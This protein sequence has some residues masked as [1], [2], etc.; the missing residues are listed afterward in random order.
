M[1]PA[2]RDPS[3]ADRMGRT[4][5]IDKLPAELRDALHGWLRDPGITQGEAANRG[6]ALAESL[7]LD[8]APISR[9][10][11]GRY[12]L[13]MRS[14]G[15]KLQESR[16][17][18]DA[19]I[20]KLGSAPG[21][22]TGHLVSEILR[23]LA[24]DTTLQLHE[25]TLDEAS[26]PGVIDAIAK[27]ALASRRLEDASQISEKR[28]EQIRQAARAQAAEDAANAASG[29]GLSRQTIDEIK[30]NILGVRQ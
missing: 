27:L 25:Q 13:R 29:Q 12:D 21:G 3:P 20:A 6:N 24:F 4:S 15:Q 14:V 1:S 11:V 16:R 28:A 30:R 9:H 22:Q 7:G 8:V 2:S 5:S 18:A 19:W 26:T 23:S 10:A 17:I